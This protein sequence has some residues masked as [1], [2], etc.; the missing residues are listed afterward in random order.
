MGLYGNTF[1]NEAFF[2]IS[3]DGKNLKKNIKEICTHHSVHIGQGVFTQFLKNKNYDQKMQKNV[4]DNLI[5]LFKNKDIRC[6]CVIV[7]TYTTT[8]NG[9]TTTETYYEQYFTGLYNN[10]VY[11]F[12]IR[13]TPSKSYLYLFNE[14]ELSKIDLPADVIQLA[15]KSIEPIYSLKFSKHKIIHELLGSGGKTCDSMINNIYNLVKSKYKDEYEVN[16]SLFGAIVIK[17]KK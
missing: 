9:M 10:R 14:F 8:V 7:N 2:F 4:Q 5:S 16:T 11:Y 6:T 13:Y 1:L 15:I 17:K 12:T 3:K